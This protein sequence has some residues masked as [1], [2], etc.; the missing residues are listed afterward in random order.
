MGDSFYL[1]PG[2][3]PNTSLDVKFFLTNGSSRYT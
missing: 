1:E 2:V 3:A